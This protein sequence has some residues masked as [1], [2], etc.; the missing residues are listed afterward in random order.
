MTVQ[1]S[2]STGGILRGHTSRAHEVVCGDDLFAPLPVRAPARLEA[3]HRALR[4]GLDR[5]GGRIA[6]RRAGQRHER[7][8]VDAC[9]HR[10]ELLRET[11]RRATVLLFFTRHTEEEVDVGLEAMR[12]RETYRPNDFFHAVTTPRLA[13]HALRAGL[14]ADDERLVV[15]PSRKDRERAFADVLGPYLRGERAEVDLGL[16]S[17]GLANVLEELVYRVEVR[18]RAVRAVRE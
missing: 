18:L 5:G 4:L 14:S 7:M 11:H 16:G 2:L 17:R 9:P 10:D 15:H 8:R 13:K 1:A 3:F 12:D 6:E